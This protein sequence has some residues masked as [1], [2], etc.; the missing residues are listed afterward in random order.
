MIVTELAASAL[1]VLALAPIGIM[2]WGKI[3]ARRRWEDAERARGRPG[4]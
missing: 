2:K 4:S 3:D 1:I